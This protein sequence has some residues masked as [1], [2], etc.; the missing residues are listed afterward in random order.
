[1]TFLDKQYW[2]RYAFATIM[3]LIAG[4]FGNKIKEYL[5]TDFTRSDFKLIRN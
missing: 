5:D 1:M 3:I 4:T 2:A